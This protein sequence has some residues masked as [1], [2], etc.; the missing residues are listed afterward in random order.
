M[1]IYVFQNIINSE[2]Y[3]I[4]ICLEDVVSH[5][6]HTSHFDIKSVRVYKRSFSNT[7]SISILYFPQ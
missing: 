1:S 7:L 4:K 5:L 3:T 2:N 6:E